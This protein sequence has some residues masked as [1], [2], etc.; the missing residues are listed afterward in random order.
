MLGQWIFKGV[1]HKKIGY[2]FGKC[3]HGN[4]DRR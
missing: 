4:S 1:F 2:D 3:F